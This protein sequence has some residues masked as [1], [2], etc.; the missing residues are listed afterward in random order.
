ML[1]GNVQL[2]KMFLKN[3]QI[4]QE[5]TRFV[6]SFLIK[7]QVS[8]Q[9]RYFPVKFAKLLRTP[10]FKNIYEELLQCI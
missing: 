4:S 9:H 1:T 6:V 10:I 8:L 3:L 5:S 2:K 7:L